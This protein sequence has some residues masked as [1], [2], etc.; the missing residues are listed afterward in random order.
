MEGAEISRGLADI[1]DATQDGETNQA[2]S[3]RYALSNHDRR[4][5]E[6]HRRQREAITQ[7]LRRGQP[8]AVGEFAEDAQRAEANGGSDDK[9]DAGRASIRGRLHADILRMPCYWVRPF[10]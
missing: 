6:Q 7:Q 4:Q 2:A 10:I 9:G 5:P 1:A 3:R 8:E